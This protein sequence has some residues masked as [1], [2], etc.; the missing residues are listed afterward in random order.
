MNLPTLT[1][2][3][4]RL[5]ALR[6]AAMVWM[7]AYHFCFDL[8]QFHV[9]PNADFYWDPRWTM[10]RTAIV[11]LF[12]LCAGLAQALGEP[13]WPRFWRRWL[14]IVGC[15]LAVTAGSMWMFPNSFISFGVLHGMA[16]MLLLLRVWK[17]APIVCLLAGAALVAAPQFLQA[18]FFDTRWT[19][20]IGLVT[21]KPVTEDYVP[22]AP[23]FGVMLWGYGLGR[24]WPALLSG[25]LPAFLRPLA[26][27]G[28]W[29]LSYY[30][31]H[32][33]VMLG[34]LTLTMRA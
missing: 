1:A 13:A 24:A 18:P 34:L 16:V 6:G 26:F 22:L 33:P 23:W 4:P 9:L 27:L 7:T 2:R 10:Q 32:Q 28:R 14:Q 30:M 12:L 11:S 21:H 25:D 17:P 3:Q 15:A 8:H 31:L 20:W 5:D 29:S 19:D